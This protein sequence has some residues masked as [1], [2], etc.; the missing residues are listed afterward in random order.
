[1]LG[2]NNSTHGITA[3]VLCTWLPY[4]WNYL[5][6]VLV[7]LS[8]CFSDDFIWKYVQL[9][10]MGNLDDMFFGYVACFT[11]CL[12][13]SSTSQR[14]QVC[15]TCYYGSC[16]LQFF[17]AVCFGLFVAFVLFYSMLAS[18]YTALCQCALLVFL[19]FPVVV[20]LLCIV[21]S[22]H[23]LCLSQYEW[24]YVK[25]FCSFFMSSVVLLHHFFLFLLVAMFCFITCK[26]LAA[27]SHD[28]CGWT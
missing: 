11:N 17:D 6:H 21:C 15:I 9:S 23:V 24:H 16:C 8:F 12:Y 20:C 22:C 7:Q 26:V 25:T 2:N 28:Q 4:Y 1:M 13:F 10:S 19:C 14:S 5:Q 18:S 27:E 3:Y